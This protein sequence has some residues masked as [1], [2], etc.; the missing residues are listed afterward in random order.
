MRPPTCYRSAAAVR[1]PARIDLPVFFL[2]LSFEKEIRNT[3]KVIFGLHERSKWG[4]PGQSES[5]RNITN[6]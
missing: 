2:K 4:I 3:E 5:R 6:T 1:T